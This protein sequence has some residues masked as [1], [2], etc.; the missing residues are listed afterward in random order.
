MRYSYTNEYKTW[1]QRAG[2]AIFPATPGAVGFN[3]QGPN[4]NKMAM[5]F[6]LVTSY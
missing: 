4:S 1:V 3:G 6:N 5:G 2:S